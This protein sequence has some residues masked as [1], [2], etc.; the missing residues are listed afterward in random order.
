MIQAVVNEC[1]STPKVYG[2]DPIGVHVPAASERG[3]EPVFHF[4]FLREYKYNTKNVFCTV[5]FVRVQ[6]YFIPTFLKIFL[7]YF[8]ILNTLSSLFN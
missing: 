8:I 4:V 7:I 3:V 1:L 5:L 2:F 6:V